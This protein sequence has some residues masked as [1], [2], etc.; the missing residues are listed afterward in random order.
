MGV[1]GPQLVWGILAGSLRCGKEGRE[2]RN[3]S[4]GF[5]F[6]R[7]GSFGAGRWLSVWGVCDQQGRVVYRP[8]VDQPS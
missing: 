8:Y 5:P 4:D 6:L 7:G 3:P 2:L 1:P